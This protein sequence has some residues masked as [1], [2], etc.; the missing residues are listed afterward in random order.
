MWLKMQWFD[1]DLHVGL[2]TCIYIRIAGKVPAHMD[3]LDVFMHM[4]LENKC[5]PSLVLRPEEEEENGPGF[6]CLRM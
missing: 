6:S 3:F 5:K 2:H 1:V 4:Y